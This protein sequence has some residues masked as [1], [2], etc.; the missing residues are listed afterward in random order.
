MWLFYSAAT[1]SSSVT[2]LIYFLYYFSTRAA[3]VHPIREAFSPTHTSYDL[4]LSQSWLHDLDVGS[5][6]EKEKGGMEAEI[7]ATSS[8]K[9]LSLSLAEDDTLKASQTKSTEAKLSLEPRAGDAEAS[10]T[11]RVTGNTVPTTFVISTVESEH[12]VLLP[13]S[14]TS[15]SSINTEGM[16]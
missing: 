7:V 2:K 10:L 12:Q 1:P 3:A 16:S 13:T 8:S 5:E 6:E 9:H 14:P 4:D 15:I 11:M